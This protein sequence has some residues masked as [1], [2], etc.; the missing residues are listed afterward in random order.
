MQNI[1]KNKKYAKLECSPKVDGIENNF[2][3]YISDDLKKLKNAWNIRHTDDLITSD[4]PKEIW[5]KLKD[6]LHNVCNEE[7]C[8]L[9]QKFVSSTL[10]TELLNSFSPQQ[11]KKWKKKPYEWLTT[12]DIQNVMKQYEDTYDD[13]EFIGPSPIDYDTNINNQCVWPELCNFDIEKKMLNGIS[14]IG[15]IFNLDTHD[16]PGSHWVVLYVELSKR[17]IYYFDSTKSYKREIPK[18]IIEFVDDLNNYTK[19]RFEFEFEFNYNNKVEHQKQNTECGIYCIYFITQL[20]TNKKVWKDFI[21]ERIPDAEM[22]K[23][24]NVFYNKNEI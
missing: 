4:D 5:T 1:N 14:K 11:P 20:L 8:W 7:A 17:E 22:K 23:L 18:E 15:I 6:G 24:R 16:E 21:D 2:S 3:C 12:T 10:G 13:F 9:R 19:T